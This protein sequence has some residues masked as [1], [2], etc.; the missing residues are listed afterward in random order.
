MRILKRI[1]PGFNVICESWS[2]RAGIKV[3]LCILEL[4]AEV[5]C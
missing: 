3:T 2:A 1:E 5:L 4:S